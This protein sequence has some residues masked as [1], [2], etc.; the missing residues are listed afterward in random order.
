[1]GRKVS[2]AR[3]P[4]FNFLGSLPTKVLQCFSFSGGGVI[5]AASARGDGA[6]D[7]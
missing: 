4:R 1:M 5:D 6:V 7:F 3:R 2:G